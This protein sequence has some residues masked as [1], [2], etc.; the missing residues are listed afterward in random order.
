M[1]RTGSARAPHVFRVR[2]RFAGGLAPRG[3]SPAAADARS[4]VRTRFVDIGNPQQISSIRGGGRSSIPHVRKL[5]VVRTCSAR[6]PHMLRAGV[7]GCCSG[8]RGRPPVGS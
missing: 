4:G 8:G 5:L 3:C 6:A 7:R 2:A 1:L